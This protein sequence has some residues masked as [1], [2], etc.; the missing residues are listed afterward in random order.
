MPAAVA[1]RTQAGAVAKMGDDDA[2]VG[3]LA[4]CAGQ[5]SRDVLV[6]QSVKAVTAQAVCGNGV[7]QRQRLRD[8]GLGAVERGIKTC[9]LR[10]FGAQFA[11]RLDRRQVV[12]LVQRCERCQRVEFG[13][14]RSI[15]DDR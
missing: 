5:C 3:L 6:R 15:D 10:E 11:Q 2:A 1:H 9:D 12:R 13:D 7:R 4:Q 14:A 8:R